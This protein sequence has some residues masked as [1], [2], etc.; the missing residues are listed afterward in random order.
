MAS[1]H[2]FS[3][4]PMADTKGKGI[5]YEEEDEPIQL[6]E[7]D[8]PHTIREFNMSL[9]GKILNPKK[10]NVEKLIKSMPTQWGMQDKITAND[11]GNGRFLF[12]FTTEKDLQSVLSQGPFHFNFCMFVLVRWEPIVHDEYPWN[13]P[14]WVEITGILLHL[15]TVKNLKRI[16]GKL[17]HIDTMELAAGRLLVDVDTRKPL[18]F[19][20]K[21]Q[22]PGGDE[23]SIQFTYDR[24]FKHCSYCGFLTHEAANCT[25]KMED[26]R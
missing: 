21:V 18:I 15:W 7:D 22:S 23:V 20:K 26:Q 1:S 19:T 4:A 10:Q 9:I 14:L 5:L 25:K 8:D 11:L 12:N 24:L 13:I 17:G 2:H 3:S 16:G 6:V